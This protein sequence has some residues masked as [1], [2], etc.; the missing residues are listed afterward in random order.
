[1]AAIDAYRRTAWGRVAEDG[2]QAAGLCKRASLVV[3]TLLEREGVSDAELWCLGMPK[4]DRGFADGDEHYVVVIDDHA[5][6]ATSRQF[7]PHDEPVT[8]R[9]REE[10][11][12]PW[13]SAVA[14][15]I[16]HV[17][18]FIGRDLHAIPANW[19]DLPGVDPPGDAIGWPYPGPWP[20]RGPLRPGP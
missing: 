5:I 19:R 13:L 10:A 11:T 18:P 1:M 17:D 7:D 14:V 15:K 3:L 9:P 20:T 16:G 2:D 6:D 4:P 12:E 8:C